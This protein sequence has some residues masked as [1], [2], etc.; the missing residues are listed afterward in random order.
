MRPNNPT[1]FSAL[2][3]W[4]VARA[5]R[6]A[7]TD[8]DVVTHITP[9]C[10]ARSCPSNT[11][12]G[13]RWSRHANVTRRRNATHR[14][15]RPHGGPVSRRD[16]G[17]GTRLTQRKM[18]A[19][20]ITTLAVCPYLRPCEGLFELATAAAPRA[21]PRWRRAPTAALEVWCGLPRHDGPRHRGAGAA[22]P[23]SPHHLPIALLCHRRHL[24]CRPRWQTTHGHAYGH[25]WTAALLAAAREPAGAECGRRSGGWERPGCW[26]RVCRGGGRA[27][28]RPCSRPQGCSR[29]PWALGFGR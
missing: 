22:A 3:R 9:S 19:W 29:L 7:A 12:K 14:A 24:G 21:A 23:Q 5:A 15:A 13:T 20:R 27:Q 28:A 16:R 2:R 1:T 8:K 11:G 25:H 18:R 17:G 4:Q 10:T 6:D 26:W